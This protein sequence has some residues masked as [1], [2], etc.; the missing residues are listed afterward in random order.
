M[1]SSTLLLVN[2]G[3]IYNAFAQQNNVPFF[4][5]DEYGQIVARNPVAVSSKTFQNE[6]VSKNQSLVS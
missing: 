3:M 4:S 6:S 5:I 2:F 1:F